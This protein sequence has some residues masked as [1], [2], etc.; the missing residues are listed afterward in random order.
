VNSRK[1]AKEGLVV[2]NDIQD[3][4]VKTFYDSAEPPNISYQESLSLLNNP[5]KWKKLNTGE[6]FNAIKV[7][8][9]QIAGELGIKCPNIHLAKYKTLSYYG[10]HAISKK[11][12]VVLNIDRMRYPIKARRTIAHE[13]KHIHQEY[14][15]F[16]GFKP[17]TLPSEEVIFDWKESMLVTPDRKRIK[18]FNRAIEIDSKHF[19]ITYDKRI[20]GELKKGS[21][22]SF[23]GDYEGQY[24][25]RRMKSWKRTHKM[26]SPE[27]KAE[28]LSKSKPKELYDKVIFE[29]LKNDLKKENP[30]LQF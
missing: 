15:V 10:G 26:L 21:M 4:I 7:Y 25:R 19:G 28:I 3:D 24:I 12:G 9:Y 13:I 11:D 22:P 2:V 18:Y 30:R 1:L 16:E 14:G 6:R 8:A 23:W 27:E 29:N 20:F 5:K 17:Q